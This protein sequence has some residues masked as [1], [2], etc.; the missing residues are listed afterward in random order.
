VIP[1]LDDY[2]LIGTT[3]VPWQGAPE[4]AAI[5]PAE[6]EY[7]CALVN[8]FFERQ[9]GPADVVW[10]FAGIRAL[11]DDGSTAASAVT[12]DYVLELDAPAGG[13]PVLTVLGG[14]LT[15]YRRLAEFALDKL[16]PHLG[17]MSGPWTASAPLPGGD[18]PRGDLDAFAAEL[19]SRWPFV[20]EAECRR[21]ARA[22]GTRA[23]RLLE[24]VRSPAD[25]GEAFGGGLT[26]L[27]VDYLMRE[28]W[29]RTAEDV[30]WR[31]SKIGLGTSAA[32]QQ[33]L[34]DYVGA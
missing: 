19:R 3:D 14:K 10:S 8:R 24:P 21:L 31:H 16:A 23:L 2:T 7:L 28:E 25:M 29:A 15:T 33:R 30:L 20:G 4:A 6:T 13:A 22:Y 9:I 18:F 12:R 1:W 34:R 11:Q 17:P 26:R 27:E 5:A 32:D